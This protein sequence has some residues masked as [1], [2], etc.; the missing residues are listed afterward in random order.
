M[1]EKN[2]SLSN[3]AWNILSFDHHYKIDSILNLLRRMKWKD[4]TNKYSRVLI[5]VMGRVNYEPCQKLSDPNMIHVF[6]WVKN[7]H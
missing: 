5:R 2:R 6:V 3:W 7:R 4:H 1:K